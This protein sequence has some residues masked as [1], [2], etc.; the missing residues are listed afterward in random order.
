MCVKNKYCCICARAQKKKETPKE[1][2]CYKIFD[3]PSAAMESTIITEGFKQ[4]VEMH[5]LIYARLIA[6]GDSST[7]SKIID[8]RPY[9][10]ITVAKI[11]CRNHLLRN[12]CNK[13]RHLITDTHFSAPDRKN[14][15]Q[16]KILRSRKY[17]CEAIQLHK[18]GKN[19]DG[20]YTDI[21]ASICHAFNIH[22]N[23]NRQLC[24]YN[25]RPDAT[26][27][28][29]GSLLWQKI[30]TL[31][32][33]LADKAHSL[34]EDVDSNVVERFNGVIAK[35]VGGKRINYSQR[36]SYQARCFGAVISFNSS[37]ILSTVQRNIY[38]NSPKQSIK[39]YEKTVNDKRDWGKN[40][41]RKRNRILIPRTLNLDYGEIVDKPDL[42]E[43]T[44]EKAKNTFVKNLMKT[45]S[46]R[47]DIEKRTILQSESGEWLELRRNMLTASNFGKIVK[48]KPTN[49]CKN[50][51]KNLLYKPNIDHVSSISHGKK[52]EKVA[53][54]QLAIMKNINVENCGLFIDEKYPFLGATPD[55]I[56]S[57]MLIEIKCPIAPFKIGIEEAI[58]Q[59]KM[60][61]YKKNKKGQVQ[62][63]NNSDWYFQVQGQL[64]ICKKKQCLFGIW[65]GDNKIKIEMIE[66]DD[67]F[68]ADV[69]EP[70][71]LK[72]YH[73]CLLPELVDPRH[74][75]NKPIRDPEYVVAENKE[76]TVSNSVA[77]IDNVDSSCSNHVVSFSKY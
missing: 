49:T 47:R 11:Y 42:D 70:K 19:E 3:V 5:G 41:K 55:G 7:Y 33:Q 22:E 66:K 14:L 15:T 27:P 28:F 53:L 61:F 39:M 73:D 51:V 1:H 30:K 29:F 36:R 20:L 23:C 72:F 44:M 6:D 46:E 62:I 24:K 8:A 56:T 74:I 4:S 48:R 59:N 40:N 35:L 34:I 38:G 16:E 75:R 13:L 77:D 43:E 54:E 67:K 26:N 65:Y 18:D 32:A 45:D 76:N 58:R 31:V 52:Y 37:N 63:N 69:M 57:D 2:K 12:Y 17:I 64:H 60:H 10:G 9:S 50:L 21:N 25:M 68:W 71:L